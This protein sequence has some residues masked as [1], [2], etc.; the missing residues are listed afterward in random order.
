MKT[1]TDYYTQMN[2][3]KNLVAETHTYAPTINKSKKQQKVEE[4]TSEKR[5]D[6]I[7]TKG[8]EYQEKKQNM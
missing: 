5:H 3:Q 6:S 4:T 8:K 2:Q 1:K 7:I